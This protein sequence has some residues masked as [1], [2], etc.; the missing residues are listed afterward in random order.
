VLKLFAW[1]P[2]F[3][4]QVEDIRGEELKVMRKFAYLTSVST[5]IATWIQ[6]ATLRD[7]ILFGSPYEDK[8]YQ[9]V[10]EACAL[11][12]DLKLLS[13][14]DLTEIGEKTRILV[15]H[16]VSFLSYID[17]VVVLVNGEISE[18]GSYQNLR[19]SKGAFSEFLDAYDKEQD[20]QT[21]SEEGLFV[22]L[23]TLLLAKA[24]VNASCILHSRLLNN[25]L[26]VPMVFF[27]TTPVGRVLNRFA[28]VGFNDHFS[29]F[30]NLSS[31]L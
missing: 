14:G 22:F 25:I 26:R 29:Y 2:S 19:A 6:N 30:S 21:H 17:E 18:V 20:N 16:G 4:T 31:L 8:R 1:E 12:P 11:G 9:D 3:Q 5:F 10:I 15:T 7:N 28:K 13:A 23:G 27:D 24:A